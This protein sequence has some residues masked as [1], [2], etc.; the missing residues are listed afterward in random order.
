MN[1][2]TV[3]RVTSIGRPLEPEYATNRAVLFLM[4]LAAIIASAAAALRGESVAMIASAGLVAAIAMFGTWA[5]GRELAPDHNIAAFVS[6]AL[7]F[8][9]LFVVEAASLLTLFVTLFL[10]RIVNRTVG[11]R[12][13]RSDS[14]AVVLLVF[15]AV[16]DLS[17][18]WLAVVAALAFC[19]D[20]I[21][22]EPHRP[23]LAFAAICLAGF[24]LS[25]S[26][27][28]LDNA[29]VSALDLLSQLI[30]SV[31]TL[32]F[33]IT[34]ARTQRVAS[35]ADATA[36]ALTPARVQ[37]G[38]LLALLVALQSL[39]LGAEGVYG[40]ALVWASLAGTSIGGL[41]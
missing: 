12:A 4:P 26:H 8:G 23:Q 5:S 37:A 16:Y 39:T 14:I 9:V 11:L 30:V 13:R 40:A 15:W 20:A 7:G 10:V 25:R 27:I 24:W 32:A 18:P 34:I 31:V 22:P 2:E 21:L 41:R 1:R 17:D 35:L 6:M 19:F 38:M 29:A 36:K 28:G 3:H 33:I